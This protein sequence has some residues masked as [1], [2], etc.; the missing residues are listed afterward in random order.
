MNVSGGFGHPSSKLANQNMM[1]S[2][3]AATMNT[4]GLSIGVKGSPSEIKMKHNSSNFSINSQ[5]K[6]Q[7]ST[8]KKPTAYVNL[9]S[10]FR[11]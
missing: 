4:S 6:A 1:I 8:I 11:N 7:V 5:K 3:N 10:S 2:G 9:D